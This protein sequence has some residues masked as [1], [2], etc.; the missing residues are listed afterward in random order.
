MKLGFTCGTFQVLSLNHLVFFER[1]K[2]ICDRLIVFVDCDQML[3][4]NKGKNHLFRF[5]NE[6]VEQFKHLKNVDDVRLMLNKNLLFDTITDIVE[7]ENPECWFWFKSGEYTFDKNTKNPV[8][9]TEQALLNGG[10]PILL[11]PTN[12]M[13]TT[14]IINKIKGLK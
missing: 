9:E 5:H 7:L 14:D 3:I 6:R 12:Y 4:D 8:E 10:L 11:P 2:K 13:S 1:C